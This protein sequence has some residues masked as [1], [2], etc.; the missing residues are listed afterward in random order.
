MKVLFVSQDLSE[1]DKKGFARK[2]TEEIKDAILFATFY[3]V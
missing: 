3:K 1:K 2:S